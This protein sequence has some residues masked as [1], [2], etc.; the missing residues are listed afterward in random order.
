VTGMHPAGGG[1]PHGDLTWVSNRSGKVIVTAVFLVFATLDLCLPNVSFAVL[2]SVP[3]L[4]VIGTGTRVQ[5]VWWYVTIFV[6][7]TF[8]LYFVKYIVIYGDAPETLLNFRL[9]NRTF[10]AITLALLG[11]GA[12]AWLYWQR[13]RSL[14][15]HTDLTEEDE[16][17][18]T[19]G[20]VG[21]ISIGLLVAA[22]DFVS[23]ANFNLPILYVV[24]LYL[25]SWLVD[26]K[27]IWIAAAAL[28]A[29]TW[30]GYF[31]TPPSTV[32]G[33]DHYFIVN[34]SLVTLTLMTMA[35]I[36]DRRIASLQQSNLN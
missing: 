14:L 10:V 31:V 36:L 2:F 1:N 23:P 22:V 13:E 4:L 7:A 16:V 17:N 6:L 34:R 12:E 24:P 8:S 26:R 9:F 20:L 27:S 35:V 32:L 3:L 15:S 30:I 11:V 33:L 21:C 29:L 5:H 19:A 28:V 25:V 18:A